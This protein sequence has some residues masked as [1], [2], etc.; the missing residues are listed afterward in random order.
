LQLPGAG[1]K[2]RFTE[3]DGTRKR[4]G[5]DGSGGD[6][7][8]KFWMHDGRYARS[9]GVLFVLCLRSLKIE[10]LKGYV[11]GL[12][13]SASGCLHIDLVGELRERGR[14]MIRV[15]ASRFVGS[16]CFGDLSA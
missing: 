6:A 5:R 7:A 12:G 15:K 11:G 1:P 13:A 9:S 8:R 3:P 2:H 16:G 10:V 14:P 4:A